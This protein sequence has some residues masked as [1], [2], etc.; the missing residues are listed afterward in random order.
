M[1]TLKYVFNFDE[2]PFSRGLDGYYTVTVKGATDVSI[3]VPD[4]S[5]DNV[6]VCPCVS[7]TGK[8]YKLLVIFKRITNAQHILPKEDR[9]AIED[10]IP[11]VTACGT[12][13]GCMTT[14]LFEWYIEEV[15]LP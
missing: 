11:S 8:L 9:E 15:F 12:K 14:E 3:N 13:K 10:N 4:F 1:I 5:R 7:A 6:S 2:S